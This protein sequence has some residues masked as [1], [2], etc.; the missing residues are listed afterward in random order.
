MTGEA[1]I[2]IGGQLQS[3]YDFL[4]NKTVT[5]RQGERHAAPHDETIQFSFAADRSACLAAAV[6]GA[7]RDDRRALREG[8]GRR[9]ARDLHRRG[10]GGG[11]SNGGC[12]REA[13]P[14]HH[15]GG[16]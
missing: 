9:V 12:L 6:G 1:W 11:E 8:E 10:C 15:G 7:G 5:K 4:P 2:R 14:G 13:V 3:C 16:A